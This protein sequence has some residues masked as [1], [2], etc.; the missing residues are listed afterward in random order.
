M[1]GKHIR[2]WRIAMD[3]EVTKIEMKQTFKECPACQ[4]SDGF[5]NMFA[6][7]GDETK[8]LFIC[9]SCHRVYD[10]GFTV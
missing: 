8:W 6:K 9:P 10:L 3:Y 5:H 4:Y 2:Y 1:S 7:E